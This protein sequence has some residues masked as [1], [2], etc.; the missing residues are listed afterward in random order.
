MWMRDRQQQAQE[1]WAREGN[2]PKYITKQNMSPDERLVPHRLLLSSLSS[3]S[4][5]WYVFRTNCEIWMFLPLCAPL[6]CVFLCGQRRS[7]CY[8]VH[9][10][11]FRRTSLAKRQMFGRLEFCVWKDSHEV[12]VSHSCAHIHQ[13]VQILIF[14]CE[15][16]PNVPLH[17]NHV[18]AHM[19]IYLRTHIQT[20][21]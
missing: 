8:G 17:W 19:C 6:F 10:K 21:L 2:A 5:W 12:C 13:R 18:C 1:E 14:V 7:P 9:L 3:S 20:L 15:M 16:Y 11:W 4:S